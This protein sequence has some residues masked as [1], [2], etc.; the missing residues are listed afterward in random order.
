[1]VSDFDGTLSP[2]DPDPLAARIEPLAR[3]AL[4]RL[5]RIARQRPERLR[6][7]VLSGRSVV[8][9]AGRVRVGGLDY[10]GNHGLEAGHLDRG[11]R[12][13]SVSVELASELGPF[14]RLARELGEGVA[15]ALGHPD[16]LFVETKGPSVAFHF[17]QA[18]D[19]VAAL[20]RIEDALSSDGVAA[21]VSTSTGGN[22]P[23]GG[24]RRFERFDGRRVVEFRPAGAGGK[25]MAMER[26]VARER[27][28]SVLVL[29]D[30]RSDAEAFRVATAGR[31]EGR[32]EALAV[33]VHG[34][35]ETPA[36]L[37][38]AADV[39][40]GSPRDAARL[41]S[42]VGSQLEREG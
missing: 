4:R 27:P 35:A 11:A 37:V 21:D 9:V 13:E 36:E 1:M 42:A 18:P 25:A 33:G 3:T 34:A 40:V 17:R 24:P 29:G 31:A 16:W 30:D 15:D 10:L 19:P 32:L 14:V 5:A 22:D 39:I 28:G 12:P 41:L 38:A 23:G 2:I 8:D 6:L 7:F 26:L 20:R